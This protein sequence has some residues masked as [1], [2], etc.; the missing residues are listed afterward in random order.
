MKPL[1]ILLMLLVATGV[2]AQKSTIE[3]TWSPGLGIYASTMT[4][5]LVKEAGL[6][7]DKG[8]LVLATVRGGPADKAGIRPGDIIVAMSVTDAWSQEGKNSRI[9][10]M[11]GS[12]TQSTNAVSSK[13]LSQKATD[14][15]H[16]EIAARPPQSYVVDP[17]GSGNFTTI[18]GA[19]FHA[20]SGDTIVLKPGRYGESVFVRPGVII[21]PSEKSLV[22]IETSQSWLL[23]GPGA[24]DISDIIF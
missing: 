21:R 1:R 10:F 2:Y 6:S 17:G 7:R 5:A 4:P 11:R 16:L 13:I 22:R 14:I 15:I 3:W 8:L 19:L 9:D 12:Q 18:A 23:K 20:R 24:F